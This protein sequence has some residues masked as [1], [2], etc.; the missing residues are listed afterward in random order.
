MKWLFGIIVVVLLG[1]TGLLL[2]TEWHYGQATVRYFFTDIECLKPKPNIQVPETRLL[3]AFY[4]I[5]TFLTSL[6]LWST[7]LL[8]AVALLGA[9]AQAYMK[10]WF[11]LSQICFF[12]Y[13][14]IDERFM[15]H[16]TFGRWFA[17]NDAYLLLGLGIVELMVLLAL[18]RLTTMPRAALLFL[19]AAG[20]FFSLMILIDARFPAEWLLRLSLEDLTKLLGA[21]SLFGFAWVLLT[22]EVQR[23]QAK[24]NITLDAN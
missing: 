1:Y 17:L 22:T 10:R 12:T 21:F 15:L 23:Y 2:W 24:L 14:S 7:A 6:L 8:F 16:E 4:G 9:E 13:L 3:L 5:N 11:Y 19:F 18:G 20:G